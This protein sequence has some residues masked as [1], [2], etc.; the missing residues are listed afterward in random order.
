LQQRLYAQTLRFWISIQKLE[1]S[2]ICAKLAKTKPIRRFNSPLRKAAG[3]FREFNANRA[4]KIPT[5]GCEP[6]SLKADVHILDKE[7]AKLATAEQPATINF[8]IDGSV[9]NGRAGI[10]I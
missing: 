9:R 10:W 8:Y 1:D 2:H 3:L 5:I 7:A 4:K 6:W